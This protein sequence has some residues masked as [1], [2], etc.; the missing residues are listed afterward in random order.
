M[1]FWVQGSTDCGGALRWRAVHVCCGPQARS[2]LSGSVSSTSGGV[3]STSGGVSNTS[4]GDNCSGIPHGCVVHGGLSSP[5]GAG[6]C[7]VYTPCSGVS[8][9]G[10]STPS[11]GVT[12]GGVSTPSGGVSHVGAAGSGVTDGGVSTPSGAG[13]R[14]GVTLVLNG[15]GPDAHRH[16][17]VLIAGGPV[18]GVDAGIHAV[19]ILGCDRCFDKGVGARKL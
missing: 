18:L 1:R 4:G 5:T 15:G 2:S 3:S 16:E 12:C 14:G 7:G 10:A 19:V 6:S 17:A 13:S 11:S 8:H 9:G